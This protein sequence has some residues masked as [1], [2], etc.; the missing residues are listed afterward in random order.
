VKIHPFTDGNGRTARLLMNLELMKHGFPPVVL[1]V[2]RR[3]E[4]YEALDRAHVD[5]DCEP[6]LQLMTE[7]VEAGFGPYWYA[8]RVTGC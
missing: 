1:P 4:Y 7:I 5:N 3:L 2:E 6:F 8:L